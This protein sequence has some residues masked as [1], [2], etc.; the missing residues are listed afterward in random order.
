MCTITD[1]TISEDDG[2]QE[3]A[4]DMEEGSGADDS[5]DLSHGSREETSLAETNPVEITS[6]ETS[7]FI[8]P[9]SAAATSLT[10]SII[11]K[12]SLVYT[13][14]D[15]STVRSLILRNHFL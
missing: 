6:R 13:L 5:T 7:D 9:I 15:K 14:S 3:I 10:S 2:R 12:S 4:L 8:T 11:S 1:T